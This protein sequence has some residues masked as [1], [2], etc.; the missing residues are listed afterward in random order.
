[1]AT[2]TH[3]FSLPK[4]QPSGYPHCG[5]TITPSGYLLSWGN[6]TSVGAIRWVALMG[7]HCVERATHRVAPPMETLCQ[8]PHVEPW[9]LS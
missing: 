8:A 3:F 7:Q 5:A 1:M 4:P 2:A 6:G 9:F